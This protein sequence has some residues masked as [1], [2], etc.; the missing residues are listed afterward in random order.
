MEFK[1]LFRR[2]SLEQIL[3]DTTENPHG[4]LAKNLKLRDLIA[5]GIAAVVGAGVFSTIG[6]AAFNGGPGV[7]FLFVITAITCG[8]TA[9]CYAEFASRV[10]VAGSAYTYSYV[11]FGELPAWIIGWALIL[12]YGIGNVVVAISWSSYFNNLLKGIGIY[13]PGWLTTGYNTAEKIYQESVAAK[14]PVADLVWTN[15]PHIFGDIPF[16]INVPAFFIVI[17]ITILAY[18]GIKESKRVANGMVVFK[19]IVLLVVIVVGCFYVNTD[20]WVPF[21]PNGFKGIMAGVSAVFFAYIGFDAISTT[22]EECENPKRDMPKAMIYSLMI[23]TVLYILTALVLTGMVKYSEFKGVSDPLAY[24][25][26]KTNLK[27]LNYIIS[28]SA[29]VATTGVLL[30]FQIGQPRIWM[31]ISRDGLLPAQ[32]AKIH[33]KYQTPSF[34]TIVT[35]FVVAIPSLFIDDVLVTDLS[36]IGTLFAFVLVSGGVLMLPADDNPNRKFK[37]PYINSRFI[38]PIL[39]LI[40]L[41]CAPVRERLSAA[42][43][44][45][46]NMEYQEY[47]FLVFVI[48]LIITT[49]YSS[50]K[51]WSLIPILGVLCCM[52]LMI[53][54]PVKSWAV[55]FGWMLLGLTI[56]FGYSYKRSKL[57][58]T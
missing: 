57:R 3:A 1:K 5:M 49:I 52:Y 58:H 54:I 2:K 47:L 23:C 44:Q 6:K 45:F 50:L 38:M 8:F 56:Y 21:A 24:V 40:F 33:P 25:F 55:F 39:T 22:A 17:L 4:E 10:P 30:V 11:A 26:E 51:S 53:E 37:M 27:T 19:L 36:S 41:I 9:M 15:A 32:F 35:G 20:N 16:I 29:V 18:I 28:L 7:V 46:G 14:Q 42:M 12:E 13:L 31:G 34:A 43:T 48:I